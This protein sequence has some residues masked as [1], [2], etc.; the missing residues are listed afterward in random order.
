MFSLEHLAIASQTAVYKQWAS[1]SSE[2]EQSFH[3]KNPK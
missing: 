2:P 3:M 1:T